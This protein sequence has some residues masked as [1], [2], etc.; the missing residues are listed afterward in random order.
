MN[1]HISDDF[2][3]LVAFQETC[4]HETQTDRRILSLS[5]D[6]PPG[7]ATPTPEIRNTHRT[8]VFDRME[9]VLYEFGGILSRTHTIS[10]TA[11]FILNLVSLGETNNVP[12]ESQQQSY[13]IIVL[14]QIM[15]TKQSV[16]LTNY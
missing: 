4:Y 10:K 1:F 12:W 9:G 7:S 16:K 3:S 2:R 15:L 8:I 5:T 14:N 13:S 11:K 6:P